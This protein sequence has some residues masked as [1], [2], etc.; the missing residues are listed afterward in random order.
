VSHH[1]LGLAF[2]LAIHSG[3]TDPKKDPF[4]VTK[5]WNGDPLSKGVRRRWRVWVRAEKAEVQYIDAW[6]GDMTQELVKAR[7]LDFTGL[8]A[9]VG[10][11]PINARKSF[12]RGNNYGGAEWWHFQHVSFLSPGITTFGD[13][14]LKIYTK[15]QLKD[16]PPWKYRDRVWNGVRFVRTK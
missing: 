10:F 16:K 8:A 1:Y 12:F 9:Q 7:A 11:V 5:S 13:E 6:R 15:Q 14:L 3:M 2:D 4:V